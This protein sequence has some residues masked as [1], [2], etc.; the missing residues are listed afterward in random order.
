MRYRT[1][2]GLKPVISVY[3]ADN[4]RRIEN[5]EMTE[6]GTTG[7]Y[8]YE[9]TFSWGKGDHSIIC[10]ESTNGVMDGLIMTVMTADISSVSGAVSA[11]LGTTSSLGDIEDTATAL[12]SQISTIETALG[13]IKTDIMKEVAAAVSGTDVGDIFDKMSEVTKRIKQMQEGSGIDFSEILQLEDGKKKDMDYLKNKTNELKAIMELNQKLIDNVANEPVVQTWY[14]YKS[15]AI[16]AI[17]IN[18]SESQTKIVP[19]KIYLPKEAKPEHVLFKGE[20]TVAYDTQQGSYYVHNNYEMKPKESKVIEI[21]MKDIWTIKLD[22]LVQLRR[23]AKKIYALLKNTEFSDR[24]KYLVEEIEENLDTIEEKQETK[25]VN[26]EVHISNYRDNLKLLDEIKKNLALTRTLLS[27]AAPFSV[28]A[29]WKVI[30]AIIAFLGILS[31]G[32][33]IIWQKQV[34]LNPDLQ[35][36][37]KATPNGHDKA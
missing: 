29:T 13:A 32:F 37:E 11:I 9:V 30:A 8:E 19:F 27:Q 3:D 34:S 28:Q 4:V 22:E 2:T 31:M 20:L 33:Y 21:E 18:P 25:A 17:I 26:P 12:N 16:K 6:I 14:E 23:E 1:Y 15:V 36:K 7:I 10:S 5:K 35:K 24:A